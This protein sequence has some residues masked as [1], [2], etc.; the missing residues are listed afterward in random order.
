MEKENQALFS[1][2]SRGKESGTLCLG[3]LMYLKL[4]VPVSFREENKET[5]PTMMEAQR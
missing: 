3:L 2:E 4:E 5:S 1:A